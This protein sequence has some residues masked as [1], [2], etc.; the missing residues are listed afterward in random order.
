MEF[1]APASLNTSYYEDS[2]PGLEI[3]SMP[4]DYFE[5]IASYNGLMLSPAFYDMYGQ[6]EFVAIVQTDAFLRKSLLSLENFNFDYL[7]APWPAGIH[8]RSFAGRLFVEQMQSPN[9]VSIRRIALGFLGHRVFVGNGGL[10]IRNV[11]EFRS[12][13]S[14]FENSNRGFLNQGINEDIII[15]TVGAECGL[16]IAEPEFAGTVFREHVSREQAEAE[17]LFGVHAPMR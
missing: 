2:F 13:V 10:S 16:V 15:S 17:D 8:Y 12:F 1:L 9:S 14:E 7:G 6:F 3:R 4:D 11:Q 5:S